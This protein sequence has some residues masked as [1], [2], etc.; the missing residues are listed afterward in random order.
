MTAP[1]GV[2]TLY[3]MAQNLATLLDNVA[4]QQ[5]VALPERRVTYMAPAV[6][7]CPQ[8][9]ILIGGWL[10]EPQPEGL[11]NCVNIRWAAQL[12]IVITRSSPAVPTASGDY[13]K[14]DSLARA[15]QIA[16]ADAELLLG[17]VLGLDEVA[18][19]LVQTP[20]AEGG[21]QSATLA[22][23]TPAFVSL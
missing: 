2:A 6:A 3:S 10:M 11:I 22:L 15:A 17:V 14:P 19:V 13:P 5:G 16:S 7:D 4:A 1:P 18:D 12:G 21:L 23:R 20:A 9:A 8:V